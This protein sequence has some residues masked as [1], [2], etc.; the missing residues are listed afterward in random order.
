MKYTIRLSASGVE[1]VAWG[2]WDMSWLWATP[3]WI[4]RLRRHNK[5]W[6]VVVSRAGDRYDAPPVISRTLES[7][8]AA[9][10]WLSE[11]TVLMESGPVTTEDVG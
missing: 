9:Q 8:R 5:D 4:G 7:R 2:N 10:H 3:Q 11:L 1:W 6:I